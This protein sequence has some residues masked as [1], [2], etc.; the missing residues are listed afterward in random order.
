MSDYT[1]FY[2][3]D[4]HKDTIAIA[5]AE[6]DGHP[7]EFLGRI[8]NRPDRMQSW[9]KRYLSDPVEKRESLMCY[10]AGPCG[11]GL[12]RYLTSKGLAC[13]VI[14]PGLTPRKPNER[15][16]TDRR[17]ALKLANYLRSGHLDPIWVPDE[18]H[19]AFRRLLRSRYRVVGDRTRF[20]HRLTKFL[21]CYGCNPPEGVNNWT[22][23]HEEWLDSLSWER[24]EDDLL[25]RELR[26]EIT[27]A[28]DRVK[29]LEEAI[30]KSV[31]TSPLRVSIEALQC[32]KGFELVTAATVCAEI[33]DIRRFAHPTSLMSYCGLV[34]GVHISGETHWETG[35]TKTGNVHLRRVLVEAAWSHR[36]PP[37]IGRTL[38]RRQK[39]Q[40]VEVIDISWRAQHR[41][42][43]RY[44]Q[45]MA[46]GKDQNK[47]IAAVARESLG[48]IWETLMVV[49]DAQLTSPAT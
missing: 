41:L 7:A 26:H 21:L 48:F 37:H 19:E 24:P 3:L 28:T 4:V 20:R 27:E 5:V 33:G 38:A 25:F 6:S 45:L 43:S 13:W 30:A 36:H 39:G 31:A 42:N 14:A 40:P 17:D 44:R 35:I 8:M 23:K 12:Y 34:P 47:A 32:L 11:Y 18:K 29:R 9:L 16:K 2:G 46:R 1:R 10:E 22:L 49:T 15:I